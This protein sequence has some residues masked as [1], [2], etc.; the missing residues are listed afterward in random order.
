MTPIN[1]LYHFPICPFSRKIRLQLLEKGIECEL[2]EEH[3]WERRSQLLALNPAGDVPVFVESTGF[4]VASHRAIAE[5][6]EE[7]KPE[8][9]LLG[10]GAQQHAE[11]RRIMDWFDDKFYT[12]VNRYILNEK[13]YRFY[14]R[15]GHPNSHAI[16]AAKANIINHLNYVTYLLK[17]RKWLAGADFSLADITAA[18]HFSVLDY[19]GDVPW[20]DFKEASEWYALVKSRPSFRPLLEDRIPGFTPV[21]HYANLD[22]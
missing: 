6:L 7:T 18:V 22:F 2:I 11:V 15:V 14:S 21:A 3:S 9:P 16:R 20:A 10:A 1:T 8:I 17:H 13:I 4:V 5:Y 19:L 12:E